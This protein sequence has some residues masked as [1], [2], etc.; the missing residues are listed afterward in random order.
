MLKRYFV[1]PDTI[2]RI[3][4]SW[5]GGAIEAY[6][7]RLA[8]QGHASRSVFRCACRFYGSSRSSLA[9][10]ARQI[11]SSSLRGSIPSSMPGRS[12]T[13]RRTRA[14][15]GKK[16]ASDA[17]NLVEQML[18]LAVPGCRRRRALAMGTAAERRCGRFLLEYL[19][20]ERGLLRRRPPL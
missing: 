12:S 1:R 4:S 16:A 5:I 19:V 15:P 13:V 17:R 20:E 2:D 6:V 14:R 3:R 18:R 10:T 8:E 11:S 7:K 9:I